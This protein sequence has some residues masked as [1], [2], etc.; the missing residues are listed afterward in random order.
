MVNMLILIFIAVMLYYEI[1]NLNL[2]NKEVY[3][4]LKVVFLVF[5]S[6]LIIMYETIRNRRFI[7]R[8]DYNTNIQ[9]RIPYFFPRKT[10]L[11]GKNE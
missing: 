6:T 3:G 7:Q 10:K 11:P 8:E 4:V 1:K 5:A 9:T 2:N